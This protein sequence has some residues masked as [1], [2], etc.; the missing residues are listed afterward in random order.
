M[1]LWDEVEIRQ[2]LKG[3]CSDNLIQVMSLAS[4]VLCNQAGIIT[5]GSQP[6]KGKSFLTAALFPEQLLT[7]TFIIYAVNGFSTRTPVLTKSLWL[8]VTTVNS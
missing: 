1:F 3:P 4:A 6:W 5:K 2:A 7:A 8:R